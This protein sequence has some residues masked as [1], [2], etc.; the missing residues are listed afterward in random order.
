MKDFIFLGSNEFETDDGTTYMVSTFLDIYNLKTLFGTDVAGIEKFNK[1]DVVKCDLDV[2]YKRKK[3]DFVAYV[4][5]VY[6]K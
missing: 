5:K 2:K 1:G 4:T 3:K 6:S